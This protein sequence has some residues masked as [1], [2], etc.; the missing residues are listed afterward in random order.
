VF[1]N[2]TREGARGYLLIERVTQPDGSA[3]IYERDPF[4]HLPTTDDD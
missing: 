2:V 4:E 1:G 3:V